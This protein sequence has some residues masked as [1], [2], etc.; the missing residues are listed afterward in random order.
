MTRSDA[1][2]AIRSSIA[3][4]SATPTLGP[5]DRETYIR[6]KARELEEVVI[7]PAAAT[8]HGVA[9]EYGLLDLLQENLSLVVAHRGDHWLG[10]VPSLGKFF[11][12]YG[13]SPDKL[14][15]L[16][17]HSGDALAEWLG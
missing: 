1:L 4:G 3:R 12:A 8:V 5:V 17:F 14:N 7:D 16:G 2:E 6:Q 15:A 9:Y 11:L 13:P 10:F